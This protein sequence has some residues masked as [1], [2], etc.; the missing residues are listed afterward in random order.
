MAD[1]F[2]QATTDANNFIHN[3]PPVV[4]EVEEA[5]AVEDA[6]SQ[7]DALTN[8]ELREV[9]LEVSSE[10]LTDKE[11]RASAVPVTDLGH[12]TDALTDTELRASPVEVIASED[13]QKISTVN[14][15]NV[16][17]TSGSTFTGVWEDV[18][19]YP[20]LTISVSTDQ[21]G[22]YQIQYS[23]DGVNVDSSLTRYYR[24]NQINVPHRF[25]NARG[26]MRIVFTNTTASDQTYLRLQTTL[27]FFS[28]LNAPI[29]STLAQDFDALVVRPTD[30]HTEVGLG[31]RQGFE[32]WNKFGYNQNISVGTEAVLSWGGSFTP[33]LVATTMSI[34]SDSVDDAVG[35]IGVEQAV[36]Y[37]IDENRLPQIKVIPMNGTTP[38]VTVEL[39][40][41][42]NRVAMFLC[43]SNMKNVGTITVTAV[44]GGSTMAEMPAGGGVTQQ[45]LFHVPLGYQFSAEWLW[46][47]TLK[48][49]GQNPTV[50]IKMWV[51]SSVSN[52]M[53][54]VYRKTL[55]TAVVTHLSENPNLPFPITEGTVLW[56]EATTDKNA[57]IVEGRFSGELVR[58]IDA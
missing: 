33:L 29:D 2:K 27:G 43:G 19:L 11:L 25:T 9:P 22:T 50:T 55:D 49:S 54:E 1:K 45:C 24:T 34:V 42:I 4:E 14:S 36:I 48:P 58:N 21:D 41:G 26:Y 40:L 44:T 57:T 10:G 38:V 53:Q 51:W 12:Q 16:L 15:S 52:G 23:P 32:L 5:I 13:V 31:R 6:T 17:L 47:N 46:A 18:T 35:G 30:F 8:E 56:L 28:D 37:Y 39:S 7:K 20:A 3:Y